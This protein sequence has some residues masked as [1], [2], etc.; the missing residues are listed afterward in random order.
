MTQKNNEKENQKPIYHVKNITFEK[1]ATKPD[2]YPYDPRLPQIAFVGR[3]NVGKSSLLNCIAN[4]KQLAHVSRTPGRTQLINFFNMNNEI[5]MV[6]LP[7]YGFA[8]APKSVKNTWDAM[9]GT[10]LQENP[11]LRLIMCLFDVRREPNEEDVL[12]LRWLQTNNI[13]FIAVI[14]KADKLNHS[15]Q[16]AAKRKLHFWLESWGPSDIILFSS[17]TRQGKDDILRAVGEVA[18]HKLADYIP[19][20]F[21]GDDDDIEDDSEE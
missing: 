2:Q 5:R 10:Y 19:E 3:S 14:T 11:D 21:D 4:R 20:D 7:G 8:K 13:P 1:S 12:L 9:I 16:I 15:G 17:V 18:A 6:D